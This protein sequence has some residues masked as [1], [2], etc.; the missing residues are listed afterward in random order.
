MDEYYRAVM[1]RPDLSGVAVQAREMVAA[2]VL[3]KRESWGV[4]YAISV[5]AVATARTAT[6]AV[7]L[8]LEHD[9][10]PRRPTATRPERRSR[11]PCGSGPRSLRPPDRDVGVDDV[12]VAAPVITLPDRSPPVPR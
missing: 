5:G 12:Y 2:G 11:R 9:R 3:T 10:G 7:G 4:L 6:L 1:A 8:S